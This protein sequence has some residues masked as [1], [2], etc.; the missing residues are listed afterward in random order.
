MTNKK[1][2]VKPK[3]ANWQARLKTKRELHVTEEAP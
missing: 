1:R 2:R 3:F